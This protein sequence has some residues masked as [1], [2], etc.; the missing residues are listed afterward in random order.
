MTEFSEMTQTAESGRPPSFFRICRREIWSD[1]FAFIS[2]VFLVILFLYIFIAA[3]QVDPDGVVRVNLRKING[4]PEPGHLLGFDPSGRDMYTQLIVGARNSVS[5]AAGIAAICCIFG[6]LIGLFAGFFG[7]WVDN[8]VM[9]VVDFFSM[10]PILMIVI[11]IV[12]L[13]PSYTVIT[14]VWVLA[15]FYWMFDARLTRAKTLQ[16]SNLDY[17]SAAKTLGTPNWKIMFTQVLPNIASIVI[18]NLTL[19]LAGLMG[20]ETGLTFLGFGLPFSSPSLGAH[21]ANARTLGP[22]LMTRWWIWLP[23][24]LLIVIMM[25]C[26]NFIGQAFKRAADA[27]QRIG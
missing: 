2:L 13:I 20:V 18:V 10:L 21:L 24:A 14:L 1:K 22:L 15:A 26:I 16:Q 27:R 11:V 4:S 9:R 17:V 7:G 19:N 23:S 5:I 8:I 3:S 6:T 25:L 12:S